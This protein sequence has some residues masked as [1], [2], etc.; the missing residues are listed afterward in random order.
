MK[1]DWVPFGDRTVRIPRKTRRDSVALQREDDRAE[2]S[3][4]KWLADQ[5]VEAQDAEEQDLAVGWP[6]V[7]KVAAAFLLAGLIAWL[8]A[9]CNVADHGGKRHTIAETNTR[10]Q[11]ATPGEDRHC[12]AIGVEE[13]TVCALAKP[14]RE[15][16]CPEPQVYGD[17][18]EACAADLADC[19]EDAFQHAEVC[20]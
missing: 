3:I 9:G 19:L 13:A 18:F 14:W 6:L 4:S 15:E 10:S 5:A 2:E 16:V 11:K 1:S 7:A 20:R 12:V 8:L 17:C